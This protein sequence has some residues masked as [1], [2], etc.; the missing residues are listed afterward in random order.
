MKPG[1]NFKII[2]KAVKIKALKNAL[3]NS[4]G[5]S[6]TGKEPDKNNDKKT[7]IK[8][9]DKN[10]QDKHIFRRDSGHLPDTPTNRDLLIEMVK[11]SKN[12]LGADQYGTE[13]FGRILDSGKQVWAHR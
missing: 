2:I 5:P 3:A 9:N 1:Q 4:N 11:N 6:Q 8:I 7:E 12:R 10:G 13:W